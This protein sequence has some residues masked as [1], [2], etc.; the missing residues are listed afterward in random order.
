MRASSSKECGPCRK[1]TANPE[2]CGNQPL[3]I[4][5]EETACAEA[6]I[7][8][9]PNIP[10]QH[11]HSYASTGCRRIDTQANAKGKCLATSPVGH[12]VE[13]PAPNLGDKLFSGTE[14]PHRERGS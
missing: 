5:P 6:N 3:P 2:D 1:S 11:W 12:D 10:F 9:Y 4:V 8:P 13:L 7:Y 14:R